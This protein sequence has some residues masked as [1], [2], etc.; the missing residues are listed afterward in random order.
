[1]HRGTKRIERSSQPHPDPA[2]IPPHRDP[3]TARRDD[4]DKPPPVTLP[5]QI[6]E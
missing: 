2:S 1:M 5:R 4:S 6:T 3:A